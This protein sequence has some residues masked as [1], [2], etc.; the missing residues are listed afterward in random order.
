[1]GILCKFLIL[2]AQQIHLNNKLYY[3]AGLIIALVCIA[4]VFWYN[5]F[6]T[7]DNWAKDLPNIG[8]SSSPRAV[9]LTNDGILDIVMG[10]GG[11][12]FT[13]TE[14]GVFALN[15]KDGS[16]LWSV[17]ARN[18]VVGSPVFKDLNADGTPDVIIGG[19][20]AILYAINGK[21]G[22]LFWEFMPATESMDIVNDR[23]ILNFYNPQFIPDQDGDGIE[24]L[25]T[26]YGGFIKAAP[27]ETDRPAGSLVIISSKDGTLLAKVEMPDGRE[28]YMSPL[29][30]DFNGNG[31]LSV[32][33]GSGGETINGHFYKTSLNSIIK[34]DLSEAKVLVDGRGK[35]F[36]APPTLA[37][38]N[39]D[40]V[41]DI[42][43]N[44]VNGKV[45]SFDGSNDKLL[46][47]AN[48][49]DE[50][51]GYTTPSPGNFN[52]DSIPDFF[53]SYG[54]GIWPSIDFA[55]QVI[56]DG[57]D[58]SIIAKDT[59]GTF[60]YASPLTFDFNQDDGD[61]A[62]V[63]VNS[64]EKQ[65]TGLTSLEVY[66]NEM[67]IYDP[68]NEDTYR[69]HDK[70]SGSNL[71][72]TP[73]LTDLDGDG[74]LDVIYCYMNDPMNFYSFKSMKVERIESNISVDLPVKWGEYMGPHHNGVYEK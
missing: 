4:A 62:L 72:S 67:L 7:P 29:V 19:R 47:E 10:G 58:G 31:D 33:F 35:G 8:S 73:L 26:A 24:D 16:L 27:Q 6:F 32:L 51:E 17:P 48:I 1:M 25:L 39:N 43:V 41:K 52:S 12:E 36:I 64:K 38:L 21:T 70:K 20:A 45:L 9:D 34:E 23:S 57:S 69:F 56:L 55:Y 60:Q 2:I 66:V 68:R 59:A 65:E 30:H 22:E 14:Y 63:V 3:T 11:R 15:G 50:F 18:Q 46:W 74:Y 53:V 44:S 61:E 40:G 28:S 42:T 5:P 13:K 37:D 54:H 71:G 49:G